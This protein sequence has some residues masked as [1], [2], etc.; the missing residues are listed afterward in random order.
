MMERLSI[1][2]SSAHFTP[3]AIGH[4]HSSRLQLQARILL[5]STVETTGSV[6]ID[7]YHFEDYSDTTA[8][9]IYDL[10]TH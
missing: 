8:L 4:D 7:D 1:R 3:S 5:H 10:I 6:L 2:F 9:V